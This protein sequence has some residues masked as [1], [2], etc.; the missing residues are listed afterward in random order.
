MFGQMSALISVETMTLLSYSLGP[1]ESVQTFVKLHEQSRGSILVRHNLDV[2]SSNALRRG[3]EG[4]IQF[5][6]GGDAR[7]KPVV[8]T[9][10]VWQLRVPPLSD[11]VVGILGVLVEQTLD[12]ITRIVKVMSILFR[13]IDV[14]RRA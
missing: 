10:R 14:S 4:L 5:S 9:K 11:I 7:C 8:A 13:R 6:V 3:L 2:R 12:Q 1:V